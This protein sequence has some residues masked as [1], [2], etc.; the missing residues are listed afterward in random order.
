MATWTVHPVPVDS[1]EARA[2]VRSYLEDIIGRYYG[3]P[4]VAGEVDQALADDPA[5]DLVAFFVGRL[6]GRSLGCAGFRMVDSETA[7]LKRVFVHSDARGRGGGAALLTAVE[8]A[9][10]ST[11]ASSIRLDTRSDLVEARK[12]YERHGYCEV[13]PF[14]DDR[15]AEHWFAKRL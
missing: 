11:G 9:A 8:E 1:A 15:Y 12:L 13:A 7:E 10:V 5:D 3:R 4:A 6:D 14:S 2:L